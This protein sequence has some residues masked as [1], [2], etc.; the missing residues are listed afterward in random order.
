MPL[1]EHSIRYTVINQ[2]SLYK[3][4]FFRENIIEYLYYFKRYIDNANILLEKCIITLKTLTIK[5]LIGNI[6]Y[7]CKGYT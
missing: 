3:E 5:S 1:L 6:Y 2:V 7:A 4:T